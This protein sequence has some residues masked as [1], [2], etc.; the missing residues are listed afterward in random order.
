MRGIPIRMLIFRLYRKCVLDVE[1]CFSE[2]IFASFEV[3]SLSKVFFPEPFRR[4]LNWEPAASLKS[5]VLYFV[6]EM[7]DISFDED[8][9]GMSTFP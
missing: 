5:D 6:E 1:I 4:C 2:Y 8:I 3:E 9:F 7:C